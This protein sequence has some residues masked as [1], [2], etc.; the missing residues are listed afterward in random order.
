[1]SSKN[2]TF[3]QFSAF[4]RKMFNHMFANMTIF[5]EFFVTNVTFIRFFSSVSQHVTSELSLICKTFT[6][7][8]FLAKKRFFI[9]VCSHMFFCIKAKK[10]KKNLSEKKNICK[11]YWESEIYA[12]F[13]KKKLLF[14]AKNSQCTI[15]IH[16]WF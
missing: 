11:N 4:Y 8:T 3:F 6:N 16:T 1:M 12:L 14:W 9:C 7:T 2:C 15:I 5:G 10:S 13:L